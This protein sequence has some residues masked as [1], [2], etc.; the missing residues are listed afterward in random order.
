MMMMI[1]SARYSR[2]LV[3]NIQQSWRTG[4]NDGPPRRADPASLA[5]HHDQ[6]SIRADELWHRI[7]LQPKWLLWGHYADQ[8]VLF[9]VRS[10]N[11]WPF[12]LRW[13]QN[14]QMYGVHHP[15]EGIEIVWLLWICDGCHGWMQVIMFGWQAGKNVTVKSSRGPNS[16][17]LTKSFFNFFNPPH[18]SDDPS[19]TP[20]PVVNDLLLDDYLLA[21]RLR[22]YII[23]RA[24][25]YYTGESVLYDEEESS[26]SEDEYTTDE[27]WSIVATVMCL[28]CKYIR[29]WYRCHCFLHSSNNQ[30]MV[31]IV[32]VPAPVKQ[33]HMIVNRLKSLSFQLNILV[34]IFIL[35]VFEMFIQNRAVAQ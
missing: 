3:D 31:S 11:G 19:V 12:Q 21:E 4:G 26:P 22:D 29:N 9:V 2:F 32:G 7:P 35:A 24:V 16:V 1:I 23:P 17:V 6:L 13:S 30:L 34:D 10:G 25:L 5:G 33:L 15:L 14:C 20:H 8:E 18:V 27:D 28:D